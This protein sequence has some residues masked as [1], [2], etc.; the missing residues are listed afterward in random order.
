MSGSEDPNTAEGS[1]NTLSTRERK[2]KGN[3]LEAENHIYSS[4]LYH[5]YA[6]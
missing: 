3:K 5:K 2:R 4:G 1:R 6:L